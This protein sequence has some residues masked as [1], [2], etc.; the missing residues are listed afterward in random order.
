MP[1]V[2]GEQL[3]DRLALGP[4]PVSDTLAVVEPARRRHR[5]GQRRRPG[6]RRREAHQRAAAR[7]PSG[8][9]STSRWSTSASACTPGPSAA[10][11]ATV[12]Y[13]APE[14]LQGG[15][16]TPAPT[17]TAS[18]AWPSSAS[19]AGRRS[20]RRAAPPEQ[21]RKA[22]LRE[23]P[24]RPSRQNAEPRHPLRRRA[25]Q[26]PRQGARRPLPDL[27]RARRRPRRRRPRPRA[28]G[29]PP[30]PGIAT[31]GWSP[32]PRWAC[33]ASRALGLAV[34]GGDDD[35]TAGDLARSAPTTAAGARRHPPA[36]GRPAPG[37]WLPV[38][39]VAAATGR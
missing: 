6:A 39:A 25:G 34:L 12:D 32:P 35:D 19:P 17:P 2:V 5:R 7:P 33:S 11:G 8:V 28:A 37:R 36:R 3:A 13:A 18:A 16:S 1:L 23:Q 9:R 38:T 22:H 15:P 29:A 24:P 10:V 27:R 20:A 14:Q 26:G 30:A 21:V 31:A 4:L